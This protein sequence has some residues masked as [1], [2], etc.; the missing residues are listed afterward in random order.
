MKKLVLA[1]LVS[2][3][4]SV[5]A[6]NDS[7]ALNQATELLKNN[8]PEQAYQLLEKNYEAVNTSNQELFL[9]GISAKQAKN[10]TASQQYFEQLLKRDPSAARVKLELAE[11]VFHLG[12]RQYARQLL[13]DVKNMNPPQAV[14]QNINNFI[15]QID[16]PNVVQPTNNPSRVQWGVW[17]ELGFMVDSNANAAPVID[18]VTMY[19]VP[20]TLSD[21]AK[22]MKDNAKI[23]K[24]GITN[25]I[26]LSDRVYWQTQLS[27]HWKG[28]NTLSILD[29]LQFNLQTGPYVALIP[30]ISLRLPVTANRVTIGHK[31]SYYYHSYGVSPQLNYQFS[32]KSNLSTAFTWAKRQY[33]NE[34]KPDVTTLSLSLS[35]Q[36]R[37]SENAR[38]GVSFNL[39]EENSKNKFD[40][41]S[42]LGGN[43][44]YSYSFNSD[45]SIS[46]SLGYDVQSYKEK[47]AAF[48]EK[49]NDK[50]FNASI[51]ATQYLNAIGTDLSLSVSYS[52]N[53]SNLELYDYTRTQTY[54]SISKSF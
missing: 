26:K 28:Y 12:N 32:S 50:L 47:E 3:S 34:N 8:Q 48:S 52:K 29:S 25:H 31:D 6:A 7:A 44:N 51:S 36:Y 53:S 45:F 4:C 46:S 42:T 38:I 2:L 20:F 30:T 39:G 27:G 14:L 24:L 1:T 19:D 23:A 18:T 15:Y 5:Y 33:Q 13:V 11:T 22:Q 41:S 35:L 9:L 49:R 54:L 40:S 10:L 17:G 37:L 21:D 16:N 43:I